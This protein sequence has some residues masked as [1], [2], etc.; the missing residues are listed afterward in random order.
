MAAIAT[1]RLPIPGPPPTPLLGWR[2]D[3][4]GAFRDPVVRLRDL[5]WRYG[6][7]VSLPRGADRFLF[8]F[9]PEYN[10][11]VLSDTDLFYN[12]DVDSTPIRL[13][14]DSAAARLA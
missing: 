3:F 7:I 9:S 2:A 6:P 1:S 4:L 12:G 11:Q 5:Y 13:P 8:V 10:R 14:K